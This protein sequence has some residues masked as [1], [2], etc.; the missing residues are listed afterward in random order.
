MRLQKAAR[1]HHTR[2]VAQAALRPKLIETERFGGARSPLHS[3]LGGEALQRRGNGDAPAVVYD[4]A[5]ESCSRLNLFPLCRHRTQT[6]LLQMP[7]QVVGVVSVEAPQDLIARRFEGL[8][9]VH[10]VGRFVLHNTGV[11]RHVRVVGQ[12][13]FQFPLRMGQ[14]L[15]EGQ[16]SLPRDVVRGHPQI[17]Q[18]G[19]VQERHAQRDEA[20]VAHRT[21]LQFQTLQDR[22][23][24]S[25]LVPTKATCMLTRCRAAAMLISAAMLVSAAMLRLMRRSAPAHTSSGIRSRRL[26]CSP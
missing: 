1:Q 12:I 16:D 9:A 24:S 18:L 10:Q 15:R 21:A 6:G 19:V 25:R 17:L 2:L 13:H 11:S 7:G 3:Y 23:L 4:G 22:L 20:A 26:G 8:S 14:D 5:F